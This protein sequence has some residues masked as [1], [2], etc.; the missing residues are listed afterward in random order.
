MVSFLSDTVLMSNVALKEDDIMW[1]RA[2]DKPGVYA[3]TCVNGKTYVGGSHSVLKRLGGYAKRR[4]KNFPNK[5]MRADVEE[6]GFEAFTVNVLCYCEL[7]ELKE[8]EAVYASQLK[9]HR[10]EG[11]YNVCRGTGQVTNRLDKRCTPEARL[12]LS[13]I[14]KGKKNTEEQK[15]RI[16][17]SLKQAYV[18]GRHRLINDEET[19]AKISATVT[20]TLK[21]PERLEKCR[22]W[23][24]KKH[25]D[26][27]RKNVSEKIK[28][29][30]QKRKSRESDIDS[31]RH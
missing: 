18:E 30:W 26:E 25:S 5:L 22:Y 23:K 1:K 19:K 10:S 17:A 21:D 3:I 6:L 7:Q 14:F 15:L 20:E 4:G 28:E 31:E 12:K 13:E 29:W 27:H 11:G 2:E 8:K 24:G 9:S 16:S